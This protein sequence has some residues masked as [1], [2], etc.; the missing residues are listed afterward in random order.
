MYKHAE[1]PPF[2]HE[3]VQL[4]SVNLNKASLTRCSTNRQGVRDKK[5]DNRL[6]GRLLYPGVPG[7]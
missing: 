3:K 5:E 6:Q 4:L 2:P 7:N 1:T